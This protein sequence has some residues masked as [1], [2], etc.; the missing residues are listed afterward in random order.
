MINNEI[1]ISLKAKKQQQNANMELIKVKERKKR[2][3]TSCLPM[4]KG[5]QKAQCPWRQSLEAKA[6]YDESKLKKWNSSSALFSKI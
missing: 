1:Q 6:N 3:Q 2:K 4:D 5:S